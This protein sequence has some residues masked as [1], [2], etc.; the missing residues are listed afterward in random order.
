MRS[1]LLPFTFIVKFIGKKL[2]KK[3]FAGIWEKLG[4]DELPA[5]PMAGHQKLAY[6]FFVNAL[7]AGIITGVASVFDQVVSRVFHYFFGAWPGKPLPDE[8]TEQQLAA[9]EQANAA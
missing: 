5:K 4:E 6:V 1:L 9:A 2:G 8:E 3:A 7:Q